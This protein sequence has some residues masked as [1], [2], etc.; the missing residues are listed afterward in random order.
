MH[1]NIILGI[2]FFIKDGGNMLILHLMIEYVPNNTF[3]TVWIFE[4][5]DLLSEKIDISSAQNLL[6]NLQYEI[7]EKLFDTLETINNPRWSN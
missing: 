3:S 6:D 4:S 5:L 2:N 1:I 7:Y